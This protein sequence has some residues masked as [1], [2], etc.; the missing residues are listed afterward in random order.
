MMS[1]QL[2]IVND[3]KEIDG[4]RLIK[5]VAL[6]C[7]MTSYAIEQSLTEVTKISLLKIYGF[8]CQPFHTSQFGRL[9]NYMLDP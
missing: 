2:G 1:A 8:L 5:A 4:P 3:N 7:I 6:C 9:T